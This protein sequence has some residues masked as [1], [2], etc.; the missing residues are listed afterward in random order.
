MAGPTV[1][2]FFAIP[3]MGYTNP[4]A[5]DNRLLWA[6]RMGMKGE[7]LRRDDAPIQYSFYLGTVGRLLTPYAREVLAEKAVDAGMDLM[8]MVDDDMLG[9][10]DCFFQLAETVVNGP[11]DICGALAFTRNPP[12]DPVLYVCEKG[13][14]AVEHKEYFINRP[15]TRY[16]RNA[17]VE[18]DAVGFGAAVFKVALLPKMKRPWFM[19]T[20]GSGEDIYFCYK[21]TR[22]AK[23]RVFSDTRIK[24]GH[25]GNNEII[26]E[27]T[28]D[29]YNQ[30]KDRLARDGEETEYA[31]QVMQ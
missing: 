30:M 31:W 10:P 27:E 24:L 5:Y 26:T 18:V 3:N 19:S 1:K 4:Q 8:F 15:L 7:A 28:H 25:V 29:T 14:D 23:A 11:A 16:P 13:Y 12:H 21:A 17:L 20:C 9:D 2:V 22:E 6:M